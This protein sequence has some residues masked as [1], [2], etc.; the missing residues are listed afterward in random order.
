MC[1]GE[2]PLFQNTS[3]GMSDAPLLD[4]LYAVLS[5]ESTEEKCKGRSPVLHNDILESVYKSVNSEIKD[6]LVKTLDTNNMVL[7]DDTLDV[8]GYCIKVTVDIVGFSEG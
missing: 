7:Q 6:I 8:D 2:K 4:I 1:V 5:A 3:I